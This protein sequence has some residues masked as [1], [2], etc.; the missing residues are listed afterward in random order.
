MNSSEMR[1]TVRDVI[2]YDDARESAPFEH[3]VTLL[4]GV[5]LIACAFLTPSRTRAVLH[6]LVGGALLLRAASGRDGLRKWSRERDAQP[7]SRILVSS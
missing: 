7:R 1:E 3:E 4:T 6:A 5:G 2:A